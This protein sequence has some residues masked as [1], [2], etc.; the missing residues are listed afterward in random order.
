[1]ATAPKPDTTLMEGESSTIQG[2]DALAK[3]MFDEAGNGIP[4]HENFLQRVHEV[5]T[6]NL[7]ECLSLLDL[8]SNVQHYLQ[9]QGFVP[10][11]AFSGL[12]SGETYVKQPSVV[13][14]ARQRVRA[15]NNL[16]PQS[17]KR[18]SAPSR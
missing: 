8:E 11:P 18:P 13:T 9:R 14:A 17:Q 2:I 1:M 15:A 6:N 16:L 7:R 10:R 3:E 12:D 4:L 5:S